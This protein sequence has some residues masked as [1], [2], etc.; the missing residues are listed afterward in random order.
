MADTEQ[1]DTTTLA[2]QLLSAY[3]ANNRVES[4]DLA[5]LI[6]STRAALVDEPAAT[7]AAPVEYVPAV[8]IRKS[9][10]SKDHLISLIDGKPYKTLKRHLA[11]NG[12]TPEEYRARYGLPKAYPMVAPAYAEMRRDVAQRNGLGQRPAAAKAAEAAPAAKAVTPAS[13][14]TSGKKAG[15]KAAAAPA[16]TAVA[17]EKAGTPATTAVTDNGVTQSTPKA[18]AASSKF[19]VKTSKPKAEAKPAKTATAEKAAKP[20]A[21][22]SPATAKTGTKPVAVKA[23]PD[24]K[25]ALTAARKKLGI[26]ISS[27]E[28]T[29]PATGEAAAPAT[30]KT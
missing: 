8:S 10:A 2:V 19:S 11:A 12:L 13:K 22:A 15:A 5:A 28:P 17:S 16:K 23:A 18:V 27:A 3:V 6:Q 9:L 26:K 25:A 30:E 14:P 7:E 21:K 20:N 24:A 29:S 1:T 4:S